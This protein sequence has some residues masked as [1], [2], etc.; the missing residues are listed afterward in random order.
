[1]AFERGMEAAVA[2]WFESKGHVVAQQI[3]LEGQTAQKRRR[4]LDVVA[5]DKAKRVFKVIECKASFGRGADEQIEKYRRLIE[6]KPNKFLDAVS[7][8]KKM[9]MR[10]GRWIQATNHGQR[11]RIEFY[12]ALTDKDCKAERVLE[13]KRGRDWLGIMR[14]KSNGALAE[15]FHGENGKKLK[16]GKPS[17]V[18]ISLAANW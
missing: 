18:K 5:Y 17:R 3:H 11:I 9:K 8:N 10:V 16:I 12:L 2:A 6:S 14:F 7:K 15:D 13:L 1:M 4:V